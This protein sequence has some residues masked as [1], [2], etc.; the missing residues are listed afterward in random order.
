MHGFY[1]WL[2][3]HDQVA[4]D[5]RN[6]QLQFNGQPTYQPEWMSGAPAPEVF[7]NHRDQLGPTV[8]QANQPAG[9]L[10]VGASCQEI[11]SP[12]II[13]INRLSI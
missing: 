13:E 3:F 4:Y 1:T 9:A 11:E 10:A 12:I 6:T 2:R 5:L 8:S 7:S